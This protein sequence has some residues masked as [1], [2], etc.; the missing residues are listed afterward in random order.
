MT[1]SF[2]AMAILKLRDEGVLSL[3]DPVSMFIPELA[4]LT[5]LTG[6]AT[7]ITIYNLL[8][9]TAG[10]PEDN[11]W[12]D[13]F[14]DI[15]DESLLEQVSQGISFS[16]IPSQQYEYSNLGYGLLGYIISRVSGIS[17]QDFISLNILISSFSMATQ[18]HSGNRTRKTQHTERDASDVKSPVLYQLK[19]IW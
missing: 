8:T 16:S 12:G 14:L 4:F 7:P 5:Y 2:T 11:P 3:T 10:F 15:T 13:R 6:D 18:K 17:F 1:K 9:M 19:K